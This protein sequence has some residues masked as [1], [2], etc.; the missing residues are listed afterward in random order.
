[1]RN[2]KTSFVLF[3]FFILIFLAACGGSDE[4]NSGEGSSEKIILKASSG[5][6]EEHVWFE[7]LFNPWMERVVEETNGQVEFELY[8]GGELVDIGSEFDALE[9]GLIDIALP[10]FNLYDQKRFPLS[11]V[12]MLPTSESDSAII[13]QAFSSLMYD[14]HEL[15]EG[16][17]FYDLE[18]GD[19]D[20]KVWGSSMGE[21]YAMSTTGDPVEKLSELDSLKLRTPT[22]LTEV[23]TKHL[24]ATPITM[25]QT[26]AY[27]ALSRGT[28]D[29]NFISVGDWKS[30][31]YHDLFSYTLEGAN[32][33]HFNAVF[34]MTNEKWESLPEN[35]RTAMDEAAKDLIVDPNAT[36]VMMRLDSEVRELASDNGS[37][38]EKLEDKSP[39][40]QEAVNKA[41]V[42]TWY[43]WIDRLEAEGHPGTEI[44]KLWRQLVEENGGEV[45]EGLEL[46]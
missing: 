20:L 37:V 46:E 2:I 19:K 32:L 45:P 30:Y 8:S 40:I 13:S 22:R 33:G 24:G 3:S 36:E 18:F 44:A 31:G 43:E 29:G 23:Y 26:D 1:M 7:A 9:S 6:P 5:V 28:I 14:E 27:D 17:S 39:V 41:M 4:T 38:F 16:K 12:T 15:K 10:V 35:V 25:P 34:G 11:E 21:P 42:E